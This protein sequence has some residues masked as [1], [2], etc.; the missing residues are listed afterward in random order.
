MKVSD[1][2]VCVIFS[3]RFNTATFSLS[4]GQVM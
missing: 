4:Q 2:H 3:Y 1:I